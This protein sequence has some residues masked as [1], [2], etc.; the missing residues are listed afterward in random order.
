MKKNY[1]GNLYIVL[2]ALV[3][4]FVEITLK[5]ATG[6]FH[7][8]QI[9]VLRFLIGGAMLFPIALRS[10]RARG[11]RFTAADARFFARLGF[12]FVCVAMMVYQLALTRT[13][14]SAVAV[15]FSCNPLF[16]TL[17]AHRLLREP[18][19]RNHVA[20]L[21]LEA[22]AVFII[23]DPLHARLDPLG[24]GL[25]VLSTLL[26]ALYCVLGKTRA[27]RLG[28]AAVTCFS[29]LFGG[30]ELLLLLL[31]GNTDAGAVF[32]EALH[33]SLFARAPLFSTLTPASLPWLLYIG[34]VNTGLGFVF[35]MLAMEKT[36]AQT[37]SIVYFLKPMLSPIL[38]YL[39]L[40]EEIT[41]AMA[42][43]IV[44]FLIGSGAA[45]LPG[46]IEEH[47]KKAA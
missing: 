36:S 24:C 7:P 13:Q 39:L 37:A 32:F 31:L 30:A 27:A 14:A 1:A 35:H 10:I 3:F 11:S 28:G 33:L 19:R 45:I 21:C 17:F 23:V 20:A 26:F 42:L 40:R 47:R 43:G 6:L 4:S 12:L 22:L 34:A 8:M 15:L 16:I 2:C 9:T 44:C 25:A 18:I 46:V 38:A 41:M 5:A 29:A